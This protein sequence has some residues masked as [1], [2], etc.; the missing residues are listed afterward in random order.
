MAAATAAL[1]LNS[2]FTPKLIRPLTSSYSSL[3]LR[4]LSRLQLRGGA[5]PVTRI[6]VARQGGR[7]YRRPS[8][9]RRRRSDANFTDPNYDPALD[10]DRIEYGLLPFLCHF[11]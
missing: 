10:L 9:G 6:A 3:S 11:G 7:H 2:T 1:S 4:S 5:R 8:G